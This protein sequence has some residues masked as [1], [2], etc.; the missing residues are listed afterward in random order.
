MTRLPL[1]ELEVL[2]GGYG[3]LGLGCDPYS[4]TN[5]LLVD[6]VKDGGLA[7]HQSDY[8]RLRR[9]AETTHMCSHTVVPKDDGVRLPAGTN[10]AINTLVDVIV[11]EIE[12]SVCKP[13]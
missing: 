1:V 8:S 11:K 9:P 10:L 7:R 4:V 12:D 3:P 2:V 13:Q 6:E 5:T